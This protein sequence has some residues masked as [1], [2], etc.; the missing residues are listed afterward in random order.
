MLVML[1]CLLMS[2]SVV[3]EVYSIPQKV[4]VIA[5]SNVNIRQSPDTKGEAL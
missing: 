3:A 2:A 1:T 5:K 4:V